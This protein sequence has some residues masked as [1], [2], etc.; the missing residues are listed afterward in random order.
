MLHGNTTETSASQSGFPL[1]TNPRD[2]TACPEYVESGWNLNNTP[3]L[4]DSLLRFE[5]CTSILLPRLSFG[6]CFSSNHWVRFIVFH[7]ARTFVLLLKLFLGIFSFVFVFL[8]WAVS[9]GR[10]KY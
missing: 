1:K 4:Q 3:K 10:R 7:E 9:L 6:M 2:V 8:G 5:S